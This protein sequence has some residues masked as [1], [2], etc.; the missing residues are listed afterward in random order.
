MIKFTWKRLGNIRRDDLEKAKSD[1]RS[2]ISD[3]RGQ[4][5]LPRSSASTWRMPTGPLPCPSLF[6]TAHS[7]LEAVPLYGSSISLVWP[8]GGMTLGGLANLCFKAALSPE[9]QR[10]WKQRLFRFGVPVAAVYLASTLRLVPETRRFRFTAKWPWMDEN[11]IADLDPVFEN[12]LDSRVIKNFDGKPRWAGGVFSTLKN[13]NE[14]INLMADKLWKIKVLD[15]SL[16]MLLCFVVPRSRNIWMSSYY[17]RLVED[18]PQLAYVLGHELSHVICQHGKDFCF[19]ETVR[20]ASLLTT[21]MVFGWFL[22]DSNYVQQTRWR[23]W[24]ALAV[25]F[26]RK[27]A[28]SGVSFWVLAVFLNVCW[29]L[30][31]RRK[32]ELEADKCGLKFAAKACFKL[33]SIPSHWDTLNFE[34][35]VP[36]WRST[37]PTAMTRKENIL[38]LLPWAEGIRTL[39][40]CQ[41]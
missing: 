21:G 31:Y 6:S 32:L 26:T 28:I 4:G 24:L 35:A 17:L 23:R 36:E 10:L 2:Q 15:E 13:G 34:G 12:F 38:D 8:F 40:G 9:Q 18:D 37:H 39:S 1:L 19:L 7:M 41:K 16:A 33:N 22:F 20:E 14:D 11:S 25:R 5:N 27:F 29:V 30:P 3:R